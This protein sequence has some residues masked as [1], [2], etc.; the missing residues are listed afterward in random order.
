L[1]WDNITLLTF[2]PFL[3]GPVFASFCFLLLLCNLVL[4]LQN[5]KITGT[6]PCWLESSTSFNPF[7]WRLVNQPKGFCP[8]ILD[9]WILESSWMLLPYFTQSSTIAGSI[10]NKYLQENHYSYNASLYC[11]HTFYYWMKFK[12][13]QLNH[14]DIVPYLASE[15]CDHIKH[16]NSAQYGEILIPKEKYIIRDQNSKLLFRGN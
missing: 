16:F 5:F 2:L 7:S 3:V 1:A 15:I 8:K 6:N 14:I 10:S 12:W 4:W 9:H 11:Q 13:I